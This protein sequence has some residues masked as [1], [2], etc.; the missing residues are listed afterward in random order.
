MMELIRTLLMLPSG[1]SSF[2]DGLDLLHFTVISISVLGAVGVTAM[3]AW[4]VTRRQRGRRGARGIP[5]KL[6]GAIIAGLLACFV[7]FWVVGYR[8]YVAM[9]TPPADSFDVYVIGK[10]W[11]WSFAYADGGASNYEL[12]VPVGK[13]VRILLT[14]RDVIHSFFV[15]NLRIK[16]DAVPGR[17]TT[18]WF[19]AI[20][21]GDYPVLCAEYCGL[22]HSRMRGR[23]IA[24]PP[25]EYEHWRSQQPAGPGLMGEVPARDDAASLAT[26]GERIAGERGCLRCHTLDG[27]PHL[28]PSWAGVY[29]QEL[30]LQD[31][32][33]VVADPEYLTRSMMDPDAQLREGFS[34]I[35]PSYQ[36]VLEAPEVAALVALIRTLQD[37][38][39]TDPATTPLP[40]QAEPP[41]TLP[42]GDGT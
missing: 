40:D 38:A 4:F 35:M 41:P 21:P 31:G 37:R 25:Q 10:Q 14:S 42:S 2:A 34:A 28:G 5:F 8:Q 12:Y 18:A 36:G 26:M 24:L 16:Q 13:P 27:T 29:M 15:P 22:S 30:A 19:T 20:E 7:G 32:S 23:V 6:E 3:T 17:M 11:M 1:A 39:P 33:R 9:A